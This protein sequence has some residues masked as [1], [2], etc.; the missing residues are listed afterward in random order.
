MVRMPLKFSWARVESWPNW[1]WTWRKM[2]R[3]RPPITTNS[4]ATVGRITATTSASRGWVRNISTVAT[5]ISRPA[6]ERLLMP[7][8]TNMRTAERS[9]VTRVIRSPVC[10]RP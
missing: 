2:R 7:G 4:T 3:I 9:L 1:S 5:M 8:P 10:I 6:P